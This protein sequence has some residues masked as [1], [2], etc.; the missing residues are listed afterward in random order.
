MSE[1]SFELLALALEAARGTAVTPPTH[2]ANLEGLIKPQAE[3]YEPV[4]SRGELEETHRSVMV[5]NWAE[6]EGKGPLDVDLLPVFLNMLVQG[7]ITVPT[8]TPAGATNSRLWAFVP[9]LTS[10]DLETATFY[11]GDPNVQI[12]RGAFGYP[13]EMKLS[14]DASGTD[15]AAMELSG[16]T[17]FPVTEGNITNVTQAN[18]GVVTSPGHGLVAGDLITITGVVG[19][20]QL[21]TNTYTVASPTATTFALSGTN[22]TGFT[23]Y[24]SGGSW[25]LNTPTMPAQTIGP[26]MP[27]MYTQVW[28]DV[29]SAI[30]TT[31]LTGRVISAEFTVPGG[32]TPKYLGVPPGSGLTYTRIGRKKRRPSGKYVFEFRDTT[33]YNMF[34]NDQLV[35]CRTRMSSSSAIE[36]VAGVTFYYY[37]EVDLYGKLKFDDWGDLEGTNRTAEFTIDGIKDATLGASFRIAVQNARTTL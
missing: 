29:A 27:S 24:T 19:M 30:G 4:E 14:V 28:M 1:I 36:T 12:F 15:G 22:T 2:Y 10:D 31:E 16:M 11:W 8:S 3:Y 18:P 35:K 17:Q 25:E 21:N 5:R 7:G 26:L 9:T 33:Q 37:C 20:T 13:D 6:W 23:A 32:I 34:K